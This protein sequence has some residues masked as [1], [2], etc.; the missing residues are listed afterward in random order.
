MSCLRLEKRRFRIGDA[1]RLIVYGDSDRSFNAVGLRWI[2][3]E[4]IPIAA[5]AVRL[6]LLGD[7]ITDSVRIPVPAGA[8]ELY[9]TRNVLIR[10]RDNMWY[11]EWYGKARSVSAS[12]EGIA[13]VIV[14]GLRRYHPEFIARLIV[15][16]VL[17]RLMAGRGYVPLHAA[18]IV[19]GDSGCIIAGAAG[20]GKSTLLDGL[21][22]AGYGFLSDD[23]MFLGIDENGSPLI[24]AV[25]ENIRLSK[26][27]RGPKYTIVPLV[28]TV[29]TARPEI[30]LLL[31]NE[32]SGGDV[33]RIP[34]GPAEASARLMQCLP[35]FSGHD[36]CMRAFSCIGN[37]CAGSHAYR[38]TGRSTPE[39]RLDAVLDIIRRFA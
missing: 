4:D 34:V 23:R 39:E 16:P 30:V 1:A 22:R 14:P 37:I 32:S 33:K 19:A 35:P 25:P 10:S 6:F 31:D 20:S 5:D 8:T 29:F 18:G 15:R 36:V 27:P 3:D 24:H 26:T 38:L 2:E 7:R 12:E 21:L 9:A 13:I 28:T 11:G 17:D